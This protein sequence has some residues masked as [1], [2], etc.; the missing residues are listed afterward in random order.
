MNCCTCAH[1]AHL[2]REVSQGAL[3]VE[4][5]Q[6]DLA[7]GHHCLRALQQ[8]ASLLYHLGAVHAQ[9][10]LLLCADAM[11]PAGGLLKLLWR[12]VEAV[13]VARQHGTG[14]PRRTPAGLAGRLLVGAQ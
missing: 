1:A 6:Q 3:A 13:N 10:V 14:R 4:T 2:D 11:R 8:N 9:A 7:R 5:L 12:E